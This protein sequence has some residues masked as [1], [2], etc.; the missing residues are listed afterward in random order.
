MLSLW[1]QQFQ[2][3]LSHICFCP[4]QCGV[5]LSH[6]GISLY[7][8]NMICV[9][10]NMQ[11]ARNTEIP[12][13]QFSFRIWFK[14]LHMTNSSAVLRANIAHAHTCFVCNIKV[15]AY[16]NDLQRRSVKLSSVWKYGPLAVTQLKQ[17]F[18]L[19]GKVYKRKSHVNRNIQVKWWHR[20]YFDNSLFNTCSDM[21]SLNWQ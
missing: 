16:W 8:K 20:L 19:G 11:L 9:T 5:L 15:K 3:Q 17:L 12:W 1:K 7:G 18:F 2:V 10:V 13:D 14:C 4:K 21:L 6:I